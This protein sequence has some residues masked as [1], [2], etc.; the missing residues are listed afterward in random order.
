MTDG[1]DFLQLLFVA[2]SHGLDLHMQSKLFHYWATWLLT[3]YHVLA[4]TKK[5][6]LNCVLSIEPL[7]SPSSETEEQ[8]SCSRSFHY[9]CH[10]HSGMGR[11]TDCC[12]YL[13]D[14]QDEARAW[15]PYASCCGRDNREGNEK[16]TRSLG[17][18][19]KCELRY[20]FF[21]PKCK[22]VSTDSC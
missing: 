10:C 17:W 21:I 5:I 4:V 16:I 19:Q 15:Q 1:Y 6:I 11:G 18:G 20:H 12:Q 8:G 22:Y 14:T 9:H 13:W 3:Y 2:T 7:H